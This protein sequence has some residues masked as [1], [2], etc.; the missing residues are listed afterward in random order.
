MP[1]GVLIAPN[2]SSAN[3]VDDAVEQARRAYDVGVRQLWLGQ[4]FDYD[5][6]GLA[7]LIGA[8]VPGVAVGTSVVPINP[9]H[10]LIVAAAAQTAQAA[11]HG[12]F[13]LG[14]G[15][16]VPF[17]EELVFGLSTSNTVQ[18]LHEYLTVLRAVRDDRTVNFHGARVT[19]VDPGVLP[20]ALAGATPFP[21]YV[22]AMGPRALRVA[23]EL[24]DGTIPANAGPR[25]MEG[26]IAPTIAQAA[27]DAGRP[28][29]RVIAMVSVAV[30]DDVDAA[31]AAAAESLAL[32]DTIPS[33][34]KVF[35]RE[36]VSSAVE[37]AVLGTAET[38][39]RRLKT[40]IDAGATELAL[41]PL[42]TDSADL[43][44][45]WEVAAAF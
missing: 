26:F 29:P 38:V 2:R 15:L 9:R 39:S 3:V 8:A 31:R 11:T 36:G 35:A 41:L 45:V 13:S 32:Y 5:A 37:L 4:Q 1:A 44:R 10:P 16:G 17:V 30:T 19:A 42:Q 7:A 18:R 12:R 20:V 6:I 28:R 34:Q 22:A 43:Q 40:Y 14:V 21:L 24:A 25:T 33:Y 23:G 27:S